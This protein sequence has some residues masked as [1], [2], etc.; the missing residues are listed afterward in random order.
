V[1]LVGLE[2]SGKEFCKSYLLCLFFPKFEDIYE[3]KDLAAKLEAV[4]GVCLTPEAWIEAS[5]S[6]KLAEE[7]LSET[8]GL[9]SHGQKPT[10][11]FVVAIELRVGDEAVGTTLSD[12]LAK[13]ETEHKG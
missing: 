8:T 12:N 5:R 13:L 1:P 3:Q 2:S 11:S 7:Q 6:F 4:L 9:L 10:E